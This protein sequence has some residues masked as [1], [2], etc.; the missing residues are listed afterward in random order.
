MAIHVIQIKEVKITLKSKLGLQHYTIAKRK[1]RR[2]NPYNPL[3]YL[4]I[5]SV[6]I[7]SF[8]FFGFVG[9]WKQLDLR[10]PFKW[11]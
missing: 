6:I 7:V 8:L 9:M 10:N 2:I 1:W 5:A 11:Q 4:T 3:S